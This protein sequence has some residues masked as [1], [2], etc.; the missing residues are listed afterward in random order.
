M[1]QK[2]EA[3]RP[4]AGFSHTITGRPSIEA[5]GLP[6]V[7]SNEEKKCVCQE[8]MTAE[9]DNS[10]VVEDRKTRS[11]LLTIGNFG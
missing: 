9:N 3:T 7:C 11:A 6:R 8:K 4:P 10:F 1:Y 2:G 5:F